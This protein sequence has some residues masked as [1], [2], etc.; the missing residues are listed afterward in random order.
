[1]KFLLFTFILTLSLIGCI[2]N[3]DSSLNVNKSDQTIVCATG[4]IG[5]AQLNEGK[6]HNQL[7]NLLVE[8]WSICSKD[9]YD[10]AD[11]IERILISNGQIVAED[12][13][14]D[15]N[16]V[17]SFV[18]AEDLASLLLIFEFTGWD[19]YQQI[20]S[21]GVSTELN[22]KLK[23][24]VSLMEG[25]NYA[26][27]VANIQVLICEYYHQNK[28]GLNQNELLQFG[29]MVDVAISSTELWLGSEFNGQNKYMILQDNLTSFCDDSILPRGFW[30][31]IIL[32]DALGATSA[33]MS[34]LV[35]TGGASAIPNP[36]LG[37]IPTAGVI[38]VIGG[39]AMSLGKAL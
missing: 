35:A 37:G 34:S 16:E 4:D 14:L 20:D 24:L 13:D 27:D 17:I 32:A 2:K 26:Q 33:V 8:Q 19:F 21:L 10:V 6:M 22:S 9:A 3:S 36:A 28:S 11:E 29:V 15:F 12:N 7:V 5:Y 23:G 30:S 25:I 38:G 39:A 31:D 1:M 18:N